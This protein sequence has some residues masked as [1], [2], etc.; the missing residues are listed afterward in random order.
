[1][2]NVIQLIKKIKINPLFWFV[3]G[4]GVLSG[5][6]KEVMMVFSIVFIHEM[7]HSFAA[8]YYKWRIRKIE[9]LP[10]VE[11]QKWRSM[12]IDH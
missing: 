11:L 1:M 10:L 4:I 9:L 6:F 8:Q 5:Y 3:I 12:G 7:G 2:N